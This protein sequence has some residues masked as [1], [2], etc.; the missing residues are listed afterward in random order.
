MKNQRTFLKASVTG[1]A[2]LSALTAVANRFSNH[3]SSSYK[4]SV[5]DVPGYISIKDFEFIKSKCASKLKCKKRIN[6]I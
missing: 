6:N 3:V 4:G 2:G 1:V 5:K